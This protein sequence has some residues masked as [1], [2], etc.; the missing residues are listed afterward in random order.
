MASIQQDILY[1]FNL[2]KRKTIWKIND[3]FHTWSHSDFTKHYT[4]FIVSSQ[5]IP[6]MKACNKVTY[7][8]Q[9]QNKNL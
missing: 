3:M 9:Q 6:K 4:M 2:F 7:Q 5:D 1:Y 8:W